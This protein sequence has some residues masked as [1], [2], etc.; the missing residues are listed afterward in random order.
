MNS[1]PHKYKVVIAGNHE[2]PL[3]LDLWQRDKERLIAEH[4]DLKDV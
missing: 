2:M 3:D 4:E 1:L